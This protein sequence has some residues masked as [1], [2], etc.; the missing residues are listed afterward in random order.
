M[1][2]SKKTAKKQT[3]QPSQPHQHNMIQTLIGF[4]RR[5][6]YDF[7]HLMSHGKCVATVVLNDTYILTSNVGVVDKSVTEPGKWS[8]SYSQPAIDDRYYS[9]YDRFSTLFTASKD[10]IDGDEFCSAVR[11]SIDSANAYLSSTTSGD[12]EP[13]TYDALFAI[14]QE[15]LR[16]IFP[17]NE[18]QHYPFFYLPHTAFSYWGDEYFIITRSSV[19]S[20]ASMTNDAA[21]ASDAALKIGWPYGNR[22]YVFRIYEPEFSNDRTDVAIRTDTITE[23][24]PEKCPLVIRD[25]DVRQAADK[26]CCSR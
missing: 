7:V 17:D 3:S 6:G 11:H 18:M 2:D 5:K 13:F 20:Y 23:I 4:Y 9:S 19:F 14:M 12:I 22:G 8:R 21:D 16:N 10:G 25:D 24:I 1:A 26:W 15:H